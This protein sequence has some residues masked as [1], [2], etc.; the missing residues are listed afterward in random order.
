MGSW[1]SGFVCYVLACVCTAWVTGM[2]ESG[3]TAL[4]IASCNGH[5]DVVRT[6]LARGAEVTAAHVCQ[7]LAM[8]C[9]QWAWDL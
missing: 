7:W 8:G 4:W 3:I 6:L 9:G 1:L 5:V 2:Q